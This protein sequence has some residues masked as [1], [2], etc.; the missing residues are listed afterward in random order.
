MILQNKTFQIRYRNDFAALISDCIDWK[1]SKPTEY[2]LEILDALTKKRRV[3]VRSL[4]GVGKTA[5][6]A[7]AILCFALVW[8]GEDWKVPTTASA[9]RQL[10]HFL[11]PE[12][13]KWARRIV[14]GK[15]GREAFNV[16][17]LLKLNL[18][19]KTGEAFALASDDHT[20]LEGAH[21]DHLLY[22]FDES[23]TIP[24]ATFDAAEGAFASGDVYALAS[25]TPGEPDGRFYEIQSRKPGF[26]DW[27]IYQI[28]LDK[29]IKAG[30]V[31]EE[32]VEQ[33][34]TQWAGNPA[35]FQ[36]RVLG[37]FASS[38][39]DGVVPLSWV[40]RAIE[41]WHKWKEI[42]SN[43]RIVR[44]GV[45]IARYG[46][47]T[48]EFAFLNEDNVLTEIR[49]Y[50]HEDTM[51]VS[52]RLA[53]I[54][55]KHNPM[56]LIDIIG[57]GAGVYDRMR[58][59]GYN[60]Y[61]FSAGEKTDLIDRSGEIGFVDKRSAAWW[62]LREML[63]PEL[64]DDI[65]LPPDDELIGDLTAPKWRMLSGGKLKVESKDEIRKRIGRSTNKGDSVIQ[66][67]WNQT[68]GIGILV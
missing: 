61:P 1:D 51:Q 9:W 8:D 30:R 28:T 54:G 2:Q 62:N 60:V 34:K 65:A 14:W 3:C 17:E 18:K 40:E 43:S 24:S 23:K 6:A 25:S 38:D 66:A 53:G 55:E 20:T 47:D 52:G 32:W 48:T 58:E 10:T 68:S 36:N 27:F 44:V 50:F 26:E 12:V 19:L 29:A 67:F 59:G 64:G 5:T 39:E 16:N 7:W 57:I 41:R 37:E 13:R 15:V 35:L 21:A 49:T 31:S 46:N 4:H 11:W 63:E 45:D 56:F 22:V 42:D 33:R